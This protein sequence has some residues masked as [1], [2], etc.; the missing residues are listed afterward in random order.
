[1][2]SYQLTGTN[3]HLD[4]TAFFDTTDVMSVVFQ[5]QPK[6]ATN[7]ITSRAY[8]ARRCLPLLV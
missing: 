7:L 1:L 8:G 2:V 3:Y 6:P 4:S 5:F